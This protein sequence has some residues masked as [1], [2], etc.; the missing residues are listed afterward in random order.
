MNRS[1]RARRSTIDGDG[2]RKKRKK[3]DMRKELIY[4][5][6]KGGAEARRKREIERGNDES[7]G[8]K[9]NGNT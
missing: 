9:R 1:T 5:G 2:S 3:N 8:E 6:G 4:A 7:T